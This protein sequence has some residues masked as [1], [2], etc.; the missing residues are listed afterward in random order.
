MSAS[1]AVVAARTGASRVALLG[2]RPGAGGVGRVMT[3]LISGL[4]A[5]DLDVDQLQPPG[6]YPELADLTGRIG[7]VRLDAD[8]APTAIRQFHAYLDWA[9]PDAILSN[10]DQTHALLRRD[11]FPGGRPRTLFRVGTNLPEKLRQQNRLTAPWRQRQLATL[12]A[13]ADALVGISPGV[14]RA[15]AAMLPSTPGRRRPELFTI[16]NPVDRAAIGAAAAEPVDHPWL[17]MPDRPVIVSVGRLVRAKDYATLLRAFCRLH[18]KQPCRLVLV[19]D[20]RQRKRLGALA[21]RLGVAK[22]LDLAGHRPNPFPLVA[23]ADLFV[24]SSRFEGANNALMEAVA[25]GTPCVATDCP[26]GPGDILEQ[27]ALGPLVAP[28]DDRAL[29]AAMRRTLKHPPDREALRA[30]A[31]RFDLDRSVAAYAEALGIDGG[32]DAA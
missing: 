15:L 11:A 13:E 24:V 17:A 30:S 12:L 19:G 14:T 21:K 18:R 6:D 3:N 9:A 27:G 32:D 4:L 16:W 1:P 26:S 25:L 7:Q 22:D 23:A 2:F 5:R 29:A 8:D 28:G 20:G 31:A 10:K